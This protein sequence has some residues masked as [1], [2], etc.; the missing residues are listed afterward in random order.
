[1]QFANPPPLGSGSQKLGHMM[2]QH[3]YTIRRE[4][5]IDS[6]MQAPSTTVASTLDEEKNV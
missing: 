3:V 2:P 1:M 5:V 4:Y 6:G